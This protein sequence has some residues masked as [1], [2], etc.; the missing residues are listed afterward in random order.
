MEDVFV[1]GLVGHESSFA[2]LLARLGGFASNLW[3][4]HGLD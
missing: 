1:C 2:C 3:R 4:P